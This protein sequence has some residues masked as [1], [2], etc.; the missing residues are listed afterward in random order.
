MI[1][2]TGFYVG[3]SNGFVTIDDAFYE[4]NY[5]G[6]MTLKSSELNCSYGDFISIKVK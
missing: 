1:T 2:I 6:R 4:G 5:I 3:Y